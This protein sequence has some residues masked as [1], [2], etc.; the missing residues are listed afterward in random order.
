MGT[1]RVYLK[2]VVCYRK[3][4][5]KQANKEYCMA[6][7]LKKEEQEFLDEINLCLQKARGIK[8]LM[9]RLEVALKS[10]S[11]DDYCEITHAAMQDLNELLKGLINTW[12]LWSSGVSIELDRLNKLEQQN[13][14]AKRSKR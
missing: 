14:K 8:N 11:K 10:L 3:S 4:Q 12:D 2:P 1:N 9:K 13:K 7:R 5:V 6:K